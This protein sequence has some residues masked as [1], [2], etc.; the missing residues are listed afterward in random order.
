[1]GVRVPVLLEHFNEKSYYYR[2]KMTPLKL[3]Q[4]WL[5]GA[6]AVLLAE[7]VSVKSDNSIGLSSR[8]LLSGSRKFQRV[9][10]KHS[11]G[12]GI[13]QWCVHVFFILSNLH[14]YVKNQFA[15]QI[16]TGT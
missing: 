10:S 12:G 8:E 13:F 11:Y 2:V 15:Y 5:V 7:Q 4:V 6:A 1:M 14:M 9:C 16:R 3:I